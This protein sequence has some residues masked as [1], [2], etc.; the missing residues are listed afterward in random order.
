MLS[1][2]LVF[3]VIILLIGAL[4]IPC[5]GGNKNISDYGENGNDEDYPI[6][7][8]ISENI[9]NPWQIFW[10]NIGASNKTKYFFAEPAVIELEYFKNETVDI[11]WGVQNESKDMW[12]RFQPDVNEEFTIYFDVIYPPNI[13]KEALHAT[14][15]PPAFDILEYHEKVGGT[16]AHAPQPKTVLNLSLDINPKHAIPV[17]DFILTV[18]ATVHMKYGNLINIFRYCILALSDRNLKLFLVGSHSIEDL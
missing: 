2:G 4:F 8:F 10:F 6:I 17:K 5:V 11:I 14:F 9:G 1:K 13:N 3:T 12:H 7:N 18:K 15:N 16:E